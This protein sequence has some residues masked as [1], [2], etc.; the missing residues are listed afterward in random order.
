MFAGM[1]GPGVNLSIWEMVSSDF[2]NNMVDICSPQVLESWERGKDLGS[3]HKMQDTVSAGSG[4]VTLSPNWV[5]FCWPDIPSP[6]LKLGT[7][8]GVSLTQQSVASVNTWKVDLNIVFFD[9]AYTSVIWIGCHIELCWPL[10][11]HSGTRWR[12]VVL[13]F[14]E[15]WSKWKNVDTTKFFV[16]Q[17]CSLWCIWCMCNLVLVVMKC[18]TCIHKTC[19]LKDKF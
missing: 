7:I 14:G 10:P 2:G 15:N 18:L 8:P 11:K 3:Y 12:P 4:S 17:Y 5:S 19:P 13:Q 1:L 9:I 16:R 6:G